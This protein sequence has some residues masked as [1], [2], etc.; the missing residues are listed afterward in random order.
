M[1]FFCFLFEAYANYIRHISP[2]CAYIHLIFFQC[3]SYSEMTTVNTDCLFIPHMQN[4]SV[5]VNLNKY[6]IREELFEFN[7][8]LLQKESA[9]Q[10]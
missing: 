4:F 10:S 6:P 9:S 7:V 5:L 1:H 3:V 8:S 2:R